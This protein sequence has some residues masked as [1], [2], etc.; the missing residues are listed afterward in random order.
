VCLSF[1]W[2]ETGFRIFSFQ[3]KEEILKQIS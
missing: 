3:P 1:L 2:Q